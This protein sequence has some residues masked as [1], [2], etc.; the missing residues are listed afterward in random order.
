MKVVVRELI[1]KT[2]EIEAAT[3]A[4]ACDKAI[5]AYKAGEPG[6]SL[7]VRSYRAEVFEE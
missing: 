1:A 3:E 4:E 6:S 2:F 7:T 5:A